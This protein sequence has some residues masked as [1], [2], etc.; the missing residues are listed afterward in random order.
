MKT[1]KSIFKGLFTAFKHMLAFPFQVVGEIIIFF[2]LLVLGIGEVLI[3]YNKI[4]DLI[5][6]FRK[7]L[8]EAKEGK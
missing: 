1:I 2:G 6:E 5:R 7:Q 8:E 3:S 4:A